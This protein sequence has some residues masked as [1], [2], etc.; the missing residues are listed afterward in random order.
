M[1]K[2]LPALWLR[3]GVV[4]AAPLATAVFKAGL[5]G[6]TPGLADA[7]APYG[8]EPVAPGITTWLLPL[9]ADTVVPVAAFRAGLVGDTGVLTPAPAPYCTP[10]EAPGITIWLVG[11]PP[12]PALFC[13][14]AVTLL[15]GDA[16]AIPDGPGRTAFGVAVPPP[17][18]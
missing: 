17:E 1:L 4:F 14:A 16:E 6:E 2:G 13:V 7:P 9:A 10:L 5:T 18:F 11:A 8:A 15:L 12:A 3:L